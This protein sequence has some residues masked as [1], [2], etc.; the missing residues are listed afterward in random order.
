MIL[1]L[2]SISDG[3]SRIDPQE[4]DQ[5]WV[6]LDKDG[7][8]ILTYSISKQQMDTTSTTSIEE[9]VISEDPL[10]DKSIA[11]YNEEQHVQK[12]EIIIYYSETCLPKV[13]Q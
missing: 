4:Q 2:S 12:T 3:Q 11:E 5:A 9:G 10:S 8:Q 1:L 13:I 7:E 6:E